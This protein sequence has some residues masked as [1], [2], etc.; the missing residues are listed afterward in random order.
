MMLYRKVK[1][2]SRQDMGELS[3]SQI[4]SHSIKH[5]NAYPA[6]ILG[7]MKMSYKR[8][9]FGETKGSKCTTFA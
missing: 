1:T 6:N 3:G 4:D 5:M 9:L 8:C 7:A 2:L